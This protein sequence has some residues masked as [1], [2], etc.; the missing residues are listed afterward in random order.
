MSDWQSMMV[1]C[2]GSS[3]DSFGGHPHERT[4]AREMLMAA[5]DAGASLKDIEE[6]ARRVMAREERD[7][8]HIQ[9]Q[10]GE[11]RLLRSYFP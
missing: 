5:W 2:F 6:E 1:R 4:A 3:D 11:L 10:L 7:E 9:K 8:E